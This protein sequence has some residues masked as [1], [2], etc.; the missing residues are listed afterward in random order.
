MYQERD[1][2]M[3]KEASFKVTLFKMQ[4]P[5]ESILLTLFE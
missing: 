2:L 1:Y 3:C 4:Y 5:F